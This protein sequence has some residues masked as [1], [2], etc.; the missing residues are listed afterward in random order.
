[1][2]SISVEQPAPP[3][4]YTP[5]L[6]IVASLEKPLA[7]A[8]STYRR[9]TLFFNETPKGYARKLAKLHRHTHWSPGDDEQLLLA[10]KHFA[11]TD[12]H[13]HLLHGRK[14]GYEHV[15]LP[16]AEIEAIEF[17]PPPA[18]KS[19]RLSATIAL[20][21]TVVITRYD[22]PDNTHTVAMDE[23]VFGILGLLVRN[24]HG[25]PMEF[26]DE[27]CAIATRTEVVRYAITEILQGT[28]TV[29][30]QRSLSEQYGLSS[31]DAR[32]L[33]ARIGC[34]IIALSP[35]QASTALWGSLGTAA[36]IIFLVSLVCTMEKVSGMGFV[37]LGVAA[38]IL[39]IS[40][41]MAFFSLQW[42]REA[43]ADPD[44]LYQKYL[45]AAE[46]ARDQ[47]RTRDELPQFPGDQ[48]TPDPNQ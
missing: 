22:D 5:P 11:L 29:T 41:L 45:D 46:R 17:R 44:E 21:P 9:Y 8:N 4:P 42:K 26:T 16:I 34:I 32:E 33:V 38:L 18:G 20:G 30:I 7:Q 15:A 28:A 2:M 3:E 12:T 6:E 1:M 25:Y 47:A 48:A 43:T 37:F 35:K 31:Y 23:L 24:A 10:A 40:L 13:L 39:L 27:E 36:G 19:L 14:E